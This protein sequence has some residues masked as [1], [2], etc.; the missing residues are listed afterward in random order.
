MNNI[1]LNGS[2]V[3]TQV[4]MLLNLDDKLVDFGNPCTNPTINS[5]IK[6]DDFKLC[7]GQSV[8]K[9][10]EYNLSLESDFQQCQTG[11]SYQRVVSGLEPEFYR[12]SGINTPFRER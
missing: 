3:D 10:T 12:S 1:T 9:L 11:S 4:G 7:K 6:N 5:C 2:H 8:T